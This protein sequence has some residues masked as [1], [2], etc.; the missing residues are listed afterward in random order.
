M[1]YSKSASNL[2]ENIANAN[3]T[4]AKAGDT[5]SYTLSVKNTGKALQPDFVVQDN[6]G[7]VLEYADPL[8]VNGGSLDSNGTISWPAVNIPAGGTVQKT[9]TVKVKDPVP[10]TAP[11]ADN[12][13][14]YNYTMT[15]TYS[16]TINIKVQPPV[17]QTVVQTAST[18][19]PN[20][21][22]GSSIFIMF[23]V[24]ALAGFLYSTRRLQA[25]EAKIALAISAREGQA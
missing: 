11:A 7:D 4:T 18:S 2:T 9:F 15:N 3:N 10:N 21:G 23:I 24:T 12:P 8:N 14:G 20:T 13:L 1:T 25:K 17:T 22:P 16:N 5:I 19:L 6:I